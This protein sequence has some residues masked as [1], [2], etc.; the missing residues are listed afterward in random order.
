MAL[1]W[2]NMGIRYISIYLIHHSITCSLKPNIH[3]Y[4]N[5]HNQTH[6]HAK[7][8][9]S[10]TYTH[11]RARTQTHTQGNN[12]KYVYIY[13]KVTNRILS[14]QLRADAHSHVTSTQIRAAHRPIFS[15]IF[16]SAF[17]IS[18]YKNSEVSQGIVL[19]KRELLETQTDALKFKK[20]T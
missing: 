11:T 16:A 12:H 8:T 2:V 3:E 6:N 9:I 19:I 20:L 1:P 17:L 7:C 4:V 18:V 5:L 15:T 10:C 13:S 14:A